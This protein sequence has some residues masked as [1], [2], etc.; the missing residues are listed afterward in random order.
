MLPVFNYSIY[1]RDFSL[2]KKRADT[3]GYI[4]TCTHTA[5]LHGLQRTYPRF[6]R[7]FGTNWLVIMY[8]TPTWITFTLSSPHP[9]KSVSHMDTGIDLYLPINSCVCCWGLSPGLECARTVCSGQEK[10]DRRGPWGVA[11]CEANHDQPESSPC[12]C[13]LSRSRKTSK[14]QL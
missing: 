9:F 6:P 3:S 7:K 4:H 5:F 10:E 2:G 8:L 13:R 11:L 1:F 14:S 12:H